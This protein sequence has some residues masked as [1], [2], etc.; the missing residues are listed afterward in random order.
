M[1]YYPKG[2]ALSN[3]QKIFADEYLANGF[4]G[5][6]AALKAGYADKRAI[7]YQ[8]KLM[9][10]PAIH[11]YIQSNVNQAIKRQQAS[12][13]KGLDKLKRNIEKLD[14]IIDKTLPDV[15]PID[16][17]GNEMINVSRMDTGMKA[18]DMQARLFG[19]YAPTKTAN[20]NVNIDSH[21]VADAKLLL[22][23]LVDDNTKDY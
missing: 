4:D 23:R 19:H 7:A 9:T 14:S 1:V 12:D 17:N 3:K 22:K 11:E 18:I 10:Q 13:N 20:L 16:E 2:Y 21:E 6:K 8:A 15:L 5:Y